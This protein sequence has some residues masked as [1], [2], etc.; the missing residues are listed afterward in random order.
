M[1][2]LVSRQ[3]ISVQK[4]GLRANTCLAILVG[5]VIGLIA[6]VILRYMEGRLL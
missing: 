1:R 5:V 3:H 2:R 4:P 6:A